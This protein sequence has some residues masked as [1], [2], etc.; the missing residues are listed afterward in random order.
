MTKNNRA[1]EQSSNNFLKTNEANAASEAEKLKA[2][3]CNLTPDS[4]TEERIRKYRIYINRLSG[5]DGKE[6]KTTT[7]NHHMLALRAFLRYLLSR[8]LH[9]VPPEKISLAKTG[10]REISFMGEEEYQRFLNAPDMSDPEGIRDKAILEVLFSTGLRVSELV[11]TNIGQ[12]NFDQG[13]IAVLGKGKKLRVVFLSEMAIRSLSDYLGTR[14]AVKMN[15]ELS[16]AQ[17][18]LREIKNNGGDNTD[19]NNHNSSFIIHDSNKNDPLFLSSRG[20]RLNVRAIERLVHKYAKIAGISKQISPHTL[21][22]TFAT[23]LLSAGADI[24]SVQSM[25]G[26]SNISTTQ[27]YTHVTDQ[28][29]REIHRKFHGQSN[30]APVYRQGRDVDAKE[31]QTNKKE[32][33]GPISLE[34]KN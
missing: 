6:L 20:N 27:V 33:D 17:G 16:P 32:P 2:E 25:L 10:D 26:H 22:H 15:N 19:Q 23:D 24:R 3:S 14:G 34:A 21:R 8:G 12:I 9:V 7:Q 18:S 1:I 13:E 31:S 11:G 5:P 28:H 4:I 29:L 30:N